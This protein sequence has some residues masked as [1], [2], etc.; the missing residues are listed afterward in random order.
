MVLKIQK[1]ND[2]IML[3]KNTVWFLIS[4]AV[5][6]LL[7]SSQPT[8]AATIPQAADTASNKIKTHILTLDYISRKTNNSKYFLRLA[9]NYCDVLIEAKKD[10]AWAQ[11]FKAKIEL[12][13]KFKSIWKVLR[14]QK[15]HLE[16]S[17]V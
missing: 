12:T 14:G 7:G 13:S 10:S 1:V 3:R 11:A 5:S 9:D 2:H 4:V 17:Q 8:L 16:Q 15:I 6:I